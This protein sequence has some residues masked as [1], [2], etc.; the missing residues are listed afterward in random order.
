MAP[1]RSLALKSAWSHISGAALAPF[2]VMFTCCILSP[3]FCFLTF[4]VLLCKI[5]LL[6][7]FVCLF[8]TQSLFFIGVFNPP[9][10]HELLV[11]GGFIYLFPPD[12]LQFLHFSSFF[13]V[14]QAL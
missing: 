13:Q 6:G 4:F 7:F 5:F 10:F 14:N 12:L 2:S 3:T 9:T 1:G 8:F 11:F